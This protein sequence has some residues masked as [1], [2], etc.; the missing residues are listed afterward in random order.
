[1]DSESFW[2]IIAAVLIIL[3]SFK[4]SNDFNSFPKFDIDGSQELKG[5]S[6]I[7]VIFGHFCTIR[8][9][10][11]NHVNYIAT[12]GVA[13]FL[14]LSGFGLVKSYKSKGIN[15]SF[16]SKRIN[17]VFL[18]YWLV[19]VI[20]I[21]VDALLLKI[22]YTT[23][24]LLLTFVGFNQKVDPTM[25]FISY[26]LMFYA[27]FYLTFRLKLSDGL[28]LLVMI[29]SSAIISIYIYKGNFGDISTEFYIHYFSFPFGCFVALYFEKFLKF[30]QENFIPMFDYDCFT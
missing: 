16:I 24:D 26:I 4:I 23:K 1:M 5:L 22:N 9:L 10:N 12:T 28:K 14:F 17:K 29:I 15:A 21:I 8:F 27:V 3:L 2:V 20:W 19:S 7:F 25:W 13:V 18:P 11:L 6:I 30:F